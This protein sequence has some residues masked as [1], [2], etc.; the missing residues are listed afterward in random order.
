MKKIFTFLI[1]ILATINMYSQG[2]INNVY[3]APAV[4]IKLGLNHSTFKYNDPN[5]KSLPHNLFI[6]PNIGAFFELHLNSS[7]YIAPELFLYN[8]GHLTQ[9]IY[10]TD[11]NVTYKV[12]S[13]YFTAR[14]PICYRIN[15]SDAENV[16]PFLT[17]A[18]SCNL[19]L[20]GNIS[21]SQPNLPISEVDIAIGRA[22]M[23]RHDFS[24]FFG[25]GSQ[26][27]IDCGSFFLVTK[28]ELGYN[29]GLTN[30]FSDMEIEEYSKPENINAYNITGERKIHNVE[31]N[32]TFGIP[33]D[34]YRD[35]CWNASINY[36]KR[37]VRTHDDDSLF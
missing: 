27:Y 25:C 26:F 10:E 24:V 6:S 11:Y 16:K 29:V 15:L 13:R 19:L 12:R 31:L 33:L 9:Y 7:F 34:F 20:G 22:N 21:L 5:L 3:D 36:K 4:G 35:A 32:I 2:R 14:I 28:V 37:S 30:S 8:R 23:R 17:V 1:V 18:P